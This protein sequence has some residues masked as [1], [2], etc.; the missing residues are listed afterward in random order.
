MLSLRTSEK[1][2]PDVKRKVGFQ[3]G[4]EPWL[5][6]SPAP[7]TP[8]PQSGPDMD[9]QFFGCWHLSEWGQNSGMNHESEWG[10]RLARTKK[11]G[12]GGFL[13]PRPLGYD[14]TGK[15]L[16][17]GTALVSLVS[18]SAQLRDPSAEM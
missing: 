6:E 1:Y 2:E 7:N 4:S 8:G 10:D 17:S 16:G 12:E 14:L 9:N 18:N 13:C 11:A 15:L 3:G 5:A